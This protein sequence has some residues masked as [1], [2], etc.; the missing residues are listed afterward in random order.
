MRTLKTVIKVE[1]NG[2]ERIPYELEDH[3]VLVGQEQMSNYHNFCCELHWHHDLEL[4]SVTSGALMANINGVF[5]Q[6]PSGEGIMINSGRFHTLYTKNSE[7]CEF[8]CAILSP[9]LLCGSPRLEHSFVRPFIAS[10]APDFFPLCPEVP[11]QSE[12]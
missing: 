5:Q 11:W 10:S 2:S 7:D 8:L 6:I 4:I 9:N 12:S 3:S 1:L